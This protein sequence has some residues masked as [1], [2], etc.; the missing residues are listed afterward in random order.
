MFL[1]YAIAIGLLVGLALRGRPAGPTPL[2]F[3]WGFLAIGGFAVQIALF[4]GPISDRVG[5]FGPV[6]YVWST[7]AVLVAVL[8]NVRIPGLAIVALGAVSNLIAIIANGGYMPASASAAA[9]AGR[10]AASTYSNSAVL[11]NAV[12]APLTDIFVLPRW[13]PFSNVFSIGDVLIA[14]GIAVAI[15]VA[16]RSGRSGATA[17]EPGE[18]GAPGNLPQRNAAQ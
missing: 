9:A 1:L 17:S 12:L 16:M 5:D 3:R 2:E 14:V 10:T 7:A 11:D 15:V 18:P 6:I 4:A 8:R 13:L